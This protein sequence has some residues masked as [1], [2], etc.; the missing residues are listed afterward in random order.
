MNRD[1]VHKLLATLPLYALTERLHMAR[2]RFDTLV[3]R[4]QQEADNTAIKAYFPLYVPRS[5]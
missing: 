4:A 5:D 2:E 1:N 3:D